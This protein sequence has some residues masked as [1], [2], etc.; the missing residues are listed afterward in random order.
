[1]R[2]RSSQYEDQRSTPLKHL[3]VFKLFSVVFFSRVRFFFGVSVFLNPP[4]GLD[5][6]DDT[7]ADMPRRQ[8]LAEAMPEGHSM[9]Y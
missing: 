3:D 8:S 9:L 1:M 2:L 5:D 4:C 6:K 7:T